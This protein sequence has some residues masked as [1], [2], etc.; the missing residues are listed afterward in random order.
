MKKIQTIKK[1]ETDFFKF[2]SNDSQY[3]N[4]MGLIKKKKSCLAYTCCPVCIYTYVYNQSISIYYIFQ[5]VSC[6]R[7][8]RS[9]GILSPF[10]FLLSHIRSLKKDFLL[11]KEF[12]KIGCA[13]FDCFV[14]QLIS[15]LT[16]NNSIENF[17]SKRKLLEREK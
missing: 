9:N 15:E 5:K 13:I 3:Q 4:L 10:F 11:K 16:M 2:F 17:E 1:K 12:Q 8:I 14:Y 6:W 7:V